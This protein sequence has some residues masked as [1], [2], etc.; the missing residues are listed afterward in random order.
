MD[1]QDKIVLEGV[2]TEFDTVNR[3]RSH[4]YY[5]EEE[6]REQLRHLTLQNRQRKINR[7]INNI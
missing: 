2:F 4:F 3:G 1:K 6:F 7:I 5:T